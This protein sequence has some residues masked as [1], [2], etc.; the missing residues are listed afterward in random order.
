M[1]FFVSH[2]IFLILTLPI[3]VIG[4]LKFSIVINQSL[5]WNINIDNIQLKD[6][7]SFFGSYLGGV[8]TLIGVL[9]TINYE[10]NKY[11]HQLKINH[12]NE[13]KNIIA[14]SIADIDI[15]ALSTIYQKFCSIELD[16]GK[17]KST[18]LSRVYADIAEKR[19]LINKNKTRLCLL[20]DIFIYSEKECKNCK[21]K[22][23]L[24]NI[25]KEF[26]F[27]YDAISKKIY[28]AL[29]LLEQF[30][31][32]S[33]TNQ[34]VELLKLEYIKE[35]Q[36]SMQLTGTVKYSDDHIENLKC[37]IVST[38][39]I[40]EQLDE[41]MD[42]FAIKGNNDI[43]DLINILRKYYYVRIDNSYKIH[44]GNNGIL[45]NYFQKCIQFLKRFNN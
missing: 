37:K 7:F 13:E 43:N 34:L 26:L 22:C 28:D 38:I 5:S 20:T 11:D 4:I 40:K 24:N 15:F 44:L 33:S 42:Y 2:P 31:Y 27:K 39:D 3:V 14:E 9:V 12:L 35:N 23:E 30:V 41:Y 17:Y 8:I 25:R 29:T 19:R 6:W 10:K 1:K 21:I 32:Y 45:I 18:D 36:L 16:N